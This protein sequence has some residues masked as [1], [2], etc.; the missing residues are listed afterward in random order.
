MNKSKKQKGYVLF[1]V[2][3]L[4]FVMAITVAATSLIIFRYTLHAKG[5]LEDLKENAIY[6]TIPEEVYDNARI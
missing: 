3:I 1:V 4:S 6:Y 5:N 2:M